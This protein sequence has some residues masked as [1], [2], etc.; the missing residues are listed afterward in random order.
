MEHVALL[1]MRAMITEYAAKLN[2]LVDLAEGPEIVGRELPLRTQERHASDSELDTSEALD[3][4]GDIN[5]PPKD[6]SLEA[7]S[8]ENS[9]EHSQY[10]ASDGS[11]SDGSH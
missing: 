3:D 9:D 11:A 6:A 7:E 5:V 8:E 4:H 10:H 1:D 2:S